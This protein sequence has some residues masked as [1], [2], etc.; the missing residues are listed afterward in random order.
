MSASVLVVDDERA[1]RD[2]IGFLLRDEG[3]Q[4]RQ[5]GD[6]AEAWAEIQR[7]VPDL[8]LTDVKMPHLDGIALIRRA[9][10]EG[11]GFPVIIMTAQRARVDAPRVHHLPKPFDLDELL[12]L[13]ERLLDEAELEA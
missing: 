3:Y 12:A 11:H 4:V 7:A 13:I 9:R 10:D 5:A 2:A 1:I 6:G 8:L